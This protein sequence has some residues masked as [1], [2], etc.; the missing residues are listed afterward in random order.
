MKKATI[1]TD[2]ACSGN[3]G[4]G[5]WAAIIIDGDNI[6]EI[7]GGKKDTTNNVMELTAVVKALESLDG[8]YEVDLYTDSGYIFDAITKGWLENWK[9]NCWISSTN[10]LVKNIEIWEQIDSLLNK[11]KVNMF[12]V[13]GHANDEYNNR[14]DKL[15]RACCLH[16]KEE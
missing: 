10:K 2:G 15:A 14:C 1:Y 13:K 5:G 12:K 6:K 8:Q 7:T 4:A 16:F 3:P 9:K 11:H